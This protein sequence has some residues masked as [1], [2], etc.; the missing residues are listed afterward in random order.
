MWVSMDVM[1][2]HVW[3]DRVVFRH[4][5]LPNIIIWKNLYCAY[6]LFHIYIYIYIYIY[7]NIQIDFFNI[8]YCSNT[9]EFQYKCIMLYGMIK[10]HSTTSCKYCID[11]LSNN[12]N[13]TLYYFYNWWY[14]LQS[15]ANYVYLFNI[16]SIIEYLG[17]YF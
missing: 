9:I 15:G 5:I 17:H 6:N 3:L 4:L 8:L 1:K 14:N 7:I 10:S 13:N 16:V 2:E 12:T 11:E